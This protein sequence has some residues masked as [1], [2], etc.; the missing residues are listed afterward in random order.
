M[1][2]YEF[3]ECTPLED[4]LIRCSPVKLQDTELDALYLGPSGVFAVTDGDADPIS[5]HAFLCDFLHTARVDIYLPGEGLYNASSGSVCPVSSEDSLNDAIYMRTTLGSPLWDE[6]DLKI[7]QEQI[8]LLDGKSR[9]MFCDGEGRRYVVRNGNFFPM[10][11]H[12]PNKIMLLALLGGVF[13]LHRFSLGKWSSGLLYLLTGGLIGFGWLL[14]VLQLMAGLMRDSQKRLIAK[15]A[16]MGIP[17]YLAGLAASIVLF[18]V[19]IV[20]FG[21][22]AGFLD[23]ITRQSVQN[24]DTQKLSWLAQL[25]RIQG[26]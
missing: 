8:R 3:C 16:P 24:A 23:Q 12:N 4:T 20:S 19:Y 25:F 17:V 14:D 10:S 6:N 9:G 18:G 1:L 11:E 13:G 7:L 2:E 5:I 22:M 21:F 15:P 26:N